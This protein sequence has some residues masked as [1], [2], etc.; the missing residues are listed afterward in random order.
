MKEQSHLRNAARVRIP[1]L[2]NAGKFL[3]LPGTVTARKQNAEHGLLIKV[4]SD[5]GIV[6]WYPASKL[7]P[8]VQIV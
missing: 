8:L 7:K 6:C 3:D 1:D 2:N 4:V 5:D